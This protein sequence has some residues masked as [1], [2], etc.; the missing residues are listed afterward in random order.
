MAKTN[1]T[2]NQSANNQSANALQY[3]TYTSEKSGKTIPV[4][5]GFTGKDDERLPYIAVLEQPKAK[6]GKK[7][8]KLH[9][10]AYATYSALPLGKN[11]ERIPC[12][13]WGAD[14]RWH[15]IAKLA[16][17]TVN[18]LDA[19]TQEAY[20]A[21][22]DKAEAV[23]QAKKSEGMPSSEERRVKSEESNVQ[24]KGKKPTANVNVNVN[25][26]DNVNSLT[27]NRSTLTEIQPET[28]AKA[29]KKASETFGRTVTEAAL[30]AAFEQ[31]AKAAKLGKESKQSLEQFLK[32]I[33]EKAA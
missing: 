24:P 9:G 26:N 27:A 4:V 23:Y 12:A 17:V 5:I 30:M 10:P 22:C 7:V 32:A 3:V 18:D 14:P 1:K 2:N 29:T 19:L 16:A 15:D 21:L 8:K 33:I 13:I 25:V 28:S 20:D 11:G 6:K 31:V